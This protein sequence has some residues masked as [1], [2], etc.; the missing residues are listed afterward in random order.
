[1]TTESAALEQ[2]DAVFAGV[3]DRVV[4]LGGQLRVD[5]PADGGTRVTATLPLPH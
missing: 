3:A 2:T 4:A 1:M 5:S